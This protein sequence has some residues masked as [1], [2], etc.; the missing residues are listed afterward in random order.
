LG[1]FAAHHAAKVE[2]LDRPVGETACGELRQR[3]LG[4]AVAA[5]AVETERVVVREQVGDGVQVD[6]VHARSMALGA[7]RG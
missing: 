1:R 5:R 2:P 3:R 6:R 7:L 4:P